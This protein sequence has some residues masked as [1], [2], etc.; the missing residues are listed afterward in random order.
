MSPRELPEVL[1]RPTPDSDEV[2]PVGA[3]ACMLRPAEPAADEQA[4]VA[5][6]MLT[7]ITVERKPIVRRFPSRDDASTPCH[8]SQ[9]AGRPLCTLPPC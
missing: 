5:H 6:E 1:V 2:V 7:T 4:S 3:K 8:E 9:R